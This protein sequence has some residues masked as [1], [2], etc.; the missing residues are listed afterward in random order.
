MKKR[1]VIGD[2]HGIGI[3]KDIL[4]KEKPD[5]VIFLGD[6]FDSFNIPPLVQKINF[7]D[8]LDSDDEEE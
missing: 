6:Y 5:S 8:L 3:W 7:D 2:L 1:V 4:N